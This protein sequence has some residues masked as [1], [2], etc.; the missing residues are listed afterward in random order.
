MRRCPA[1][2]GRQSPRREGFHHPIV[3]R[4]RA[5]SIEPTPRNP[6]NPVSNSWGLRLPVGSTSCTTPPTSSP[7]LHEAK[8]GATRSPNRW[9]A[10]TPV[11]ATDV[12]GNHEQI[13][14]ADLGTLVPDGDAP[15][16]TD[17]LVPGDPTRLGS[18]RHCRRRFGPNLGARRPRGR[19]GLFPRPRRPTI[20]RR[21]SSTRPSRHSTGKPLVGW[22]RF[23][24][25]LAG[26]SCF[27]A[28][29]RA[30]AWP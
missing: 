5:G 16:L 2:P 12:G 23:N 28:A 13:H 9:P 21:E 8:A 7:A 26:R 15:A 19:N 3:R 14:S 30:T 25:S 24:E 4:H 22:R 11:V 1:R 17:A 10:G 6:R 29:F 18:I 27:L 20:G